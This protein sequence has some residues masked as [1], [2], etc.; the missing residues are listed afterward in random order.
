M[1]RQRPA[2]RDEST[3]AP[4]DVLP[5][6]PFAAMLFVKNV[7]DQ[8]QAAFQRLL[9]PPSD[10][11]ARRELQ[12]DYREKTARLLDVLHQHNDSGLA[13]SRWDLTA[14]AQ[15]LVQ[16]TLIEADIVDALG[17]ARD[18]ARLREWAIDLARR[19]LPPQALAR[20]RRS[21]ADQAAVEGRFNE[22]LAEFDDLRRDFQDAGDV[23]QA[24]Q[25]A[26]AQAV[27]LEWLGD[28]Q[29][30][31]DAITS[32]RER[33]AAIA[34]RELPVP[35][36]T[37][38]AMNR[39]RA[40]I[41]AGHGPTGEADRAAALW[42][43][44]VE[45]VEHEGRIRKARG[46]HDLAFE[47]FERVLPHYE[48]L[49]GGAAIEYQL[50]AID[51]ARGRYREAQARLERIEPA[52]ASGI[53]SGKVAGLRLLQSWVALG[54]ED[55]RSA[56]RLADDGL[57]DLET[58]ADEDLLWRL[59]WRRAEALRA[60]GR[61][62]Q[63]LAAYTDAV[64]AVDRLR[65]APLGYRLDSTS[66]RA[67]MPLVEQ[68]IAF[69]AEQQDGAACARFI[70]LVK[71]RALSSALSVPATMRSTRSPLE[72][73][74]D[75]IT[76]QL[77]ALEYRGMSGA[78]DGAEVRTRRSTLLARRV[79]LM[80]QIRLRD[81]RWRGL[82]ASPPFDTSKI[83]AT[84]KA[85]KQAAL[86]LHVHGNV[87]RSVLV[88]DAPGTTN[89]T[90]A[91]R[92]TVGE[93]RLDP[94][95]M[96]I[97]DDYAQNLLRARPDPFSLDPH[98]LQLDASMFVPGELLDRAC[99]ASS[100]LISPHGLLHLLPWP[101]MPYGSSRLFERAPVGVVPN[102][103][104]AIALDGEG[105]RAPRAA[106]VGAAR[107]AHLPNT[108]D[109]PLTREEIDTLQALYS[110]RLLTTPLLDAAA[111]E[112][113][114]RA[115]AERPDASSAI[116]HLSCHGTVSFE[117]P[118]GAGLLLAD[119]KIDA[120]EWATMRLQYEEVVLS[121][122]STG[123][124]PSSA[125]GIALLG[126]DVLGLP[127]ALLEAGARAI[128]VS[129]PKAEENATLAFMTGY[130]RRRA[131]GSSPLSAFCETQRE[132]LASTHEPYT[133]CGFVCYGVR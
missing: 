85:R 63:A 95:V 86:T 116:L 22:A 100:V 125:R 118:L 69:A 92:F 51:R 60:L 90:H 34:G 16:Q 131:D 111:T 49:G 37:A 19:E 80:E 78:A 98:D 12:R 26:L 75:E 126:D 38:D 8:A 97:L 130:H 101:S 3:A 6:D 103:T 15:P 105:A 35:D 66:L 132:M 71:S 47:R 73:E 88:M 82:T 54:L 96:S 56:L 128:V 114:V 50:A 107:Y 109:L 40:S 9:A 32:A 112:S 83:A 7:H 43:V 106:L 1:G 87:V 31:L 104:C 74:F 117:D 121:A 45:I 119:G 93:Q 55:A 11:A 27:V 84:L 91:G 10:N 17:D 28:D 18:A 58:H 42:R 24:A 89:G 81:P 53:L 68:A 57:A 77:D 2:D 21:L 23:I 115:L 110:G 62:K 41:L 52:F 133:W 36:E 120:A 127:G 94:T 44:S 113:A 5:T 67:K 29:R 59:Q 25:T 20:I 65:K 124:R 79:T 46:E 76:Q 48:T 30:A 39:E 72:R 13:P 4:R 99:T 123:W 102:L 108:A 122:C 70:E 14:T 61:T 64:D 33:V 129:I